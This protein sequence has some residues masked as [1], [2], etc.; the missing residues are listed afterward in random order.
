MSRSPSPGPEQRYQA[1]TV[2]DNS[3]F[4]AN[5][6]DDNGNDG[7]VNSFESQSISPGTEG[8]ISPISANQEESPAR[9]PSP[10]QY[11]YRTGTYAP[12]RPAY[13]PTG[14]YTRAYEEQ[15]N[16]GRSYSESGKGS[17]RSHARR[18]SSPRGPY[19]NSTY[20][21]PARRRIPSTNQLRRPAQSPY[22]GVELGYTKKRQD[23]NMSPKRKYDA[24]EHLQ[25]PDT[26]TNDSFHPSHS[27][28]QTNDFSVP[29]RN[30]FSSYPMQRRPSFHSDGPAA[31]DYGG[32]ERD[33]GE[34]DEVGPHDMSPFGRPRDRH[35]RAHGM[36]DEDSDEEE[37]F[38][39]GGSESAE[40]NK[41]SR[42]RMSQF[43]SNDYQNLPSNR[44]RT[45][46]RR[47]SSPRQPFNNIGKNRAAS[48]YS[49]AAMPWGLNQDPVMV[50]Q[51]TVSD[52]TLKK[53]GLTRGQGD[54]V[55]KRGYGANDP[56]NIA[57]I[58][59]YDTGGKSF[60][61]IVQ[62]LNNERI[63]KGHKPSLTVCS[64]TS[65]YSRNAPLMY[66]A[67]GMVFIPLSQRSKMPGQNGA[68]TGTP[69][70]DDRIDNML[71]DIVAADEAGKWERVAVALELKS[72]Q[73]MDAYS[74][75]HRF[76]M[77]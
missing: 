10:P 59:L 44:T 51:S 11:T 65:R 30:D 9:E 36:M 56:E 28:D 6:V 64:V 34:D 42:A 53:R 48:R 60:P 21:M 37:L 12:P 40:L 71:L 39:D 24:E 77:L 31:S 49:G 61:E 15:I 70:F 62:I 35:S 45:R 1:P 69:I 25:R 63:A 29:E 74:A 18:F 41:K 3:N 66:Q 17:T 14:M 54:M 19:N 27:P 68:P 55:C 47:Q 4:R 20:D 52:A 7:G 67:N 50:P 38:V 75:A 16:Q 43:S 72:G 22:G 8:S 57:I 13:D 33:D 5:T 73:H 58:N 2:D 32:L 26:F 23:L 76:A 46:T